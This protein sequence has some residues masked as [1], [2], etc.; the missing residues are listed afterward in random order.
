MAVSSALV[1]I[2]AFAFYMSVTQEVPLGRR[3]LEMAAISLGVATV[4]FGMGYLV[5]QVFGVEG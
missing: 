1:I 4:S 5:R 3:F 2:L